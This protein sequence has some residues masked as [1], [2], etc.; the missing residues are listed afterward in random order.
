MKRALLLFV[1]LVGVWLV[2]SL[3]AQRTYRCLLVDGKDPDACIPPPCEF[4]AGL[5]LA[6][7]DARAR[8]KFAPPAGASGQARLAFFDNWYAETQKARTAYRRCGGRT[9]PVFRLS[10]APSCQISPSL[11]D[12][13]KS[14]G[15]CSELVEAHYKGTEVH[16]EFC[17]STNQGVREAVVGKMGRIRAEEEVKQLKAGLLGYLASCVPDADLS[18]QLSQ[19]GLDSLAK[20]GRILRENWL[21]KR[22]SAPAR[23]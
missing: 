18:R 9:L 16:Q 5:D 15:T 19:A 21:A 20:V 10:P 11:D 7:A 2:P 6:R 14:G 3:A 17:S 23:R 22:A 12:A 4:M 8:A 1:I 13:L